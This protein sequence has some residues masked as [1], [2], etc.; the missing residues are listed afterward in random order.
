MMASVVAP[1]PRN[2]PRSDAAQEIVRSLERAM[3]ALVS[4]T[5]ELPSVRALARRA[6]VALGS[7]YQ[8]FHNREDLLVR[9]VKTEDRRL[10]ATLEA[11]LLAAEETSIKD[12]VHRC[13]DVMRVWRT[14]QPWLAHLALNH[15]FR[16]DLL[17]RV[18]A[19]AHE[20]FAGV[21]ALLERRHGL[22]ELTQAERTYIL[23]TGMMLE[24]LH[25]SQ[26]AGT[27]EESVRVQIVVN[28]L[29]SAQSRSTTDEIVELAAGEGA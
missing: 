16:P 23:C 1:K 6:G 2:V 24:S 28:L 12:D 8:Y 9:V 5:S 11:T 7:F 27:E 26:L 25:A 15:L 21:F 20:S 19:G 13:S 4:T 3:L 18:V 29:E 10:A 22:R 14:E 17:A